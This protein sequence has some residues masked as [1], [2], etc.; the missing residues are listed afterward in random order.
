MRV[1]HFEYNDEGVSAS[2]NVFMDQGCNLRTEC[3]LKALTSN[4]SNFCSSTEHPLIGF[5]DATYFCNMT[6]FAV[7]ETSFSR[8]HY[9]DEH[10]NLEANIKC[11]VGSQE[12]QCMPAN[13]EFRTESLKPAVGT[14]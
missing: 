14:W 1:T 11:L 12:W 9:L 7:L 10:L 2:S 5:Q 3:C 4:V 13:L 8:K 6:L